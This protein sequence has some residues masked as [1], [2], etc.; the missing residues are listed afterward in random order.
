MEWSFDQINK[1]ACINASRGENPWHSLGADNG[2]RKSGTE[3]ARGDV[4]KV[5]WGPDNKDPYKLLDYLQ[6]KRAFMRR[7]SKIN[8]HPMTQKHPNEGKGRKP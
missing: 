4:K 7:G 6:E 8:R 2:S 5:M 3:T 1:Y